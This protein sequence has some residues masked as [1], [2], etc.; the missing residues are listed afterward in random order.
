MGALDNYREFV[1]IGYAYTTTYESR[2]TPA[3]TDLIV[4]FEGS[5]DSTKDGLWISTGTASDADWA[6]LTTV[7]STMVG[8]TGVANGEAGI[9]PQPDAGEEALFLR[10]DGTWA[11]ASG[12]GGGGQEYL[13][14]WLES[15]VDTSLTTIPTNTVASFGTEIQSVSGYWASGNP[16]RL[17]M[18]DTGVTYVVE[19]MVDLTINGAADDRIGFVLDR[20]DSG[21]THKEY[22]EHTNTAYIYDNGGNSSIF[23]EFPPLI[24]TNNAADDFL[25]CL[26]YEDTNVY[27]NK[28]WVKFSVIP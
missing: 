19:C 14:A 27:L 24:V 17:L 13:K 3:A 10:G 23:L 1:P 16:T 2:G 6:K 8:A 4:L 7:L 18:P 28:V 15:T 11:A 22:Y 26:F 5:T 20:K 9:V 21:G 25:E 12:G